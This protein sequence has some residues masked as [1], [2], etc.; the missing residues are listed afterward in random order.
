MQQPEVKDEEI[1][2]LSLDDPSQFAVLVDKYQGPFMRLAYGVVR[3][4]EEAE[5]IVQE[6]F[7]DVYRNALKFKKQEGATFKSWAYRVVLNKAIS[8]Y[9]KLKKER[10]RFTALEPTHYE[11]LGADGDMEKELDRQ[12]TIEKLLANLPEDFQRIVKAYYI[13]DKPYAVIAEEEK[14]TLSTLKMRLFRAKKL[15]RENIS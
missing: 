10:E 5:D 6:A 15:L 14:I 4:R 8:H 11:N 13:E 2:I 12:I 3:S 7:C 9:R 1:L